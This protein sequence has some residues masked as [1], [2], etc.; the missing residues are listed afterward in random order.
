[1]PNRDPRIV[2]P[3]PEVIQL[4]LLVQFLGGEQV[5][6]ALDVAVLL[7]PALAE[8]EVLEVLVELAVEV[9]DVA[10]RAQVV[11]VVE[12]EVLL[13]G[14]FPCGLALGVSCL[15]SLEAILVVPA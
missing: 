6:R 11:G 4:R 9:G 12:V 1:M 7:H 3:R 8:R 14:V 5:R 15:R 10:G 13:V 2:I